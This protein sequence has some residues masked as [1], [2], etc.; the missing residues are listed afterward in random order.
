MPKTIIIPIEMCHYALYNNKVRALQIFVWL[1]MKSSGKIKITKQ[2]LEDMANDLG[3]KSIKTIKSN[4]DHLQEKKWITLSK[5]SGYFFISG[6]ERIRKMEG[7]AKRT[8]A[9]FDIK[10]IRNF[11]GFL[12]GSEVS[13]LIG[14]QRRRLWVTE[15]QKGGSM[16]VTHIP[17]TFYPVANMVI[18]KIFN[19]S[20]STAWEW[21]K[22]AQKQRFIRI[23]RNFRPLKVNPGVLPALRKYGEE[24]FT[25]K[26]RFWKGKIREQLPDTIA[27]NMTLRNRK[28]LR[29]D[30]KKSKHTK[31]GV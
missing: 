28:K 12:I 27:T 9:E 31:K 8:G 29:S 19:I 23:R 13:N 1:K 16:T 18:A 25:R 22:L 20:L 2:V 26:A 5:R 21:K 4:I 14:I 24:S 15:R 17:P 10:D 3:L 7:F 11:K 6:F 30:G